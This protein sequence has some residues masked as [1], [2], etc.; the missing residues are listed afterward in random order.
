MSLNLKDR[1]RAFAVHLSVS[2]V[3]GLSVLGVIWS[4]WYPPPLL[5][6]QGILDI[7]ALLL[8]V[9][10]VA[11]PTLTFIIFNRAKKSLKFDLAVIVFLQLSALAYGLNTVYQGRPV[12]LVYN[13]GKISVVSAADLVYTEGEAKPETPYLDFPVWGPELIGAKRPESREQKNDLLF[14][15]L[16]GGRDLDRRAEYYVP[17]GSLSDEIRHWVRP[18]GELLQRGDAGSLLL[19]RRITEL[20]FRQEEVGYLPV[21]GRS[22]DCIALVDLS[23]AKVIELVLV[24]PL[25]ESI[26]S[27]GSS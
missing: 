21:M 27:G 4:L 26:S 23:T 16:F 15:A 13:V 3:V 22:R 17:I 11:G 10:V 12:Y 5:Q 6:A 24:Q 20:S 25:W 1:S 7:Y 19:K 18:L 8:M 14:S 2:V 9:D